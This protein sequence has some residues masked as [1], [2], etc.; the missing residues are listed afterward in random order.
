MRGKKE[1]GLTLIEL[2][3]VFGILA[4]LAS[5]MIVKFITNGSITRAKDAKRMHEVYQIA[6]ALQ[7]YR[8]S[9]GKYPENTDSGDIGCYDGWDAGNIINGSDDKFLQPLKDEGIVHS[10]PIE[11]S[12]PGETDWEKCS[13]RYLKTSNPC[14]GCRG[15]YAILYAVCESD[16]CPVGERPDCCTCWN[17]GGETWDKRDITIFLKE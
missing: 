3:M 13:Y 17:E 2:L 1:K 16:D 10:L 8:A 14:C 12:S 4:I 15:T 9:N 11:S 5:V 7:L 6:H